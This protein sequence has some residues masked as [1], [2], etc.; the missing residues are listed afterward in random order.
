MIVV[1]T[2]LK[3]KICLLIILL[4]ITIQGRSATDGDIFYFSNLNLKDGLSQLSVLD[5]CEDAEGFIWFATRNG[6]NRYDGEHFTVYKHDNNDPSTISDSHIR[7]LLS[8][9][10]NNRIWAGTGNGLNC[11]DL[12]THQVTS[13]LIDKYPAIPGRAIISLSQDKNHN[14]WI[15]TRNGLCLW[16][17]ETGE[18]VNV[19]LSSLL[20]GEPI[21]ALYTDTRNRLYIGTNTRGLFQYDEDL[22]LISHLTTETVPALSDNSITSIFEDSQHQIW[23]GTLSAGVNKWNTQEGKI[24]P[25][26]SANS[27]LN[28]ESI[29]CFSEQNGKLMIGTFNGLG[30]L[31]LA[32]DRITPYNNF[33]IKK[34]NLSHYSVYSLYVDQIGTLWVGTYS[35]GVNYSNPLNSRFTFYHPQAADSQELLGIYGA[36][37]YDAKGNLWIATEGE[38]LLQFDPVTKESR[39]YLIDKSPQGP[40]NKNI[41]KSVWA[42]G[43]IIWCGT[44]NGAIYRFHVPDKRFTLYYQFEKESTRGIYSLFRDDDDSWWVGTTSQKGLVK[45][46]KDKRII[47]EFPV[48]QDSSFSLSSIRSFLELRDGIYLIGTRTRGLFKYDIHQKTLENYNISQASASHR[49]QNNYITTIKRCSNGDIWIGT[50]GGG[51][52]LYDEYKGI[53]KYLTTENGLPNNNV[54]AIEEYQ[55]TLWVSLDNG[56]GEINTATYEIILHNCFNGSE[57]LE[58]TPQASYTLPNGEVYFSGSNGFLSFNPRRLVLNK[59]V[60]PVVFT[61]FSVNNQLISP[62][63]KSRILNQVVNDTDEVVLQYNQGNFSIA[64][65]ALNYIYHEQNQYAYRL[66]GHDEGWN[67]VGTRKEA[68]YTN[69]A[70]GEYTFQVIASNN[71]NIWNETGKRLRIKILPPWWKTP[72]A[73]ISYLIL[74]LTVTSILTYYMHSKRKLEQNLRIKQIERQQLEEFHQTKVR[75]FTNFSH[76][77]R[78]PLTLIIS[79]LE[80]LLKQVE[81][82]PVIKQKLDLVFKNSQRLLLLVNQLMDLQKNQAGRL[83]LKVASSDLNAF[84]SEMYLAFKQIAEKNQVNFRF[85]GPSRELPTYFDANLLE[86]VIFNLLSNAF[87]FTKVGDTVD[88][89]LASITGED[90]K[91]NYTRLLFDDSTLAEAENYI[92]FK[93]SDT[94]KGIP[95]KDQMHVFTPFYQAENNDQAV[96][97]GTGIGLSLVQSIVRLHHGVIDMQNNQPKGTVFTIVLPMDKNAYSEEDQIAATDAPL[98]KEEDAT[99]AASTVPPVLSNKKILI[100]EDNHEIRHYLRTTL[101][102]HYHIIESDNG[103]DAFDLVMKE[104][105]DLVLSDIMMPGTDGLELCALIKN[106]M[107]TCHIPVILLTARTMVMHIKEGYLSGAD[108]YIIKPFHTDV[109]LVRIHNLLSLRDKLKST[110]GKHFSLEAMGIDTTTS[111]EDK[112]MQ[113]FFSIV[114]KHLSNPD[115]KADVICEE[116]ALSRTN[117]YR[118]IKAVSELSPNDLIKNKRLEVGAR[119]LIETDMNVSEVSMATGFSTLA[120]FTKSFKMAYEVSPT[121]YIRRMKKD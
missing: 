76:E 58:F 43:D 57:I 19:K 2:P 25:F 21:I 61:N 18:I 104:F 59:H 49:L 80:E 53:L 66:I 54:Y 9:T 48:K 32:T 94:G 14:I 62:G 107:Q 10:C 22:Q 111:A 44:N 55:N 108:D 26:T 114:E 46:T 39:N 79:P 83:K 77:L 5:I 23:I 67:Q 73:Y 81:L 45:L 56:I 24:T 37:D 47:E 29:R 115:L 90:L 64:Y 34:G 27:G 33:D 109:L 116:M 121:E 93:V 96:N 42:E 74:F 103:A 110:Y 112:F 38:G 20:D 50:F 16:E 89:S 99:P 84:F 91:R 113:K 105:P 102:A 4:F 63:D 41:I 119:M 7:V 15:G 100:V 31:D 87:K 69:I 68:F 11:I 17:A 13:Y 60:P 6:L 8:D 36:M 120:Y 51:L 1:F 78:T 95:K 52:Y 71:D 88:L 98:F 12:H 118:K 35:G 101:E 106:D 28:I 75:L 86:K 65:C 82:F 30:I 40:Y 97:S 117:F 3:N 85:E 72:L 70:P 92:L